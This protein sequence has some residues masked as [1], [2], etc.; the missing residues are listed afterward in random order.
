MTTELFRKRSDFTRNL[1]I[2]A[3]LTAIGCVFVFFYG[4]PG[5]VIVGLGVVLLVGAFLRSK[6]ALV[7]MEQKAI[8]LTFAEK[9]TVPFKNIERAEHL[10]NHDIELHLHS[11]KMVLVQLTLLEDSDGAWLRKALRKEIRTANA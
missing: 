4:P 3:A 9:V 6:R 7:T 1:G 2:G 11:G 8:V 10:K 5:L